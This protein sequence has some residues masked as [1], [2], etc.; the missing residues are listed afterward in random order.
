MCALYEVSTSGF[1]AWRQRPK[2][3]HVVEDERLLVE[4]RQA[5]V[6]SL[7]TYGSPRIHER[8]MQDGETVGRR[9]IERL[10]RENGIRACSADQYRR[11][12]GLDRFFGTIGNR[13]H[14]MTVT[15]PDQVWVS[16]VT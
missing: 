3:R 1:Y 11:T 2:S 10:M 6:A 9:R 12:P 14:A 7:K 4:I 15:R 8:L 5:Y 13:V 16:D